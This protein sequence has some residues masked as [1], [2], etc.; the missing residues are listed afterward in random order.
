MPASRSLRVVLLIIAAVWIVFGFLIYS[1]SSISDAIAKASTL[2]FS[3]GSLDL[4]LDLTT[5]PSPTT[6]VQIPDDFEVYVGH[7]AQGGESIETETEDFPTHVQPGQ[8]L[9]QQDEYANVIYHEDS[10]EFQCAQIEEQPPRV[11]VILQEC[12]LLISVTR[13]RPPR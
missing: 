10:W 3:K 1:F 7:T 2:S 5:S 8:I 9:L 12:A 11:L 6:E 4:S 13:L